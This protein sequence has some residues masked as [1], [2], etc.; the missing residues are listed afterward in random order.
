MQT[1]NDQKQAII[2]CALLTIG[3]TF[4]NVDVMVTS[5]GEQVISFVSTFITCVVSI[6]LLLRFTNVDV[7][8][9]HYRILIGVSFIGMT[10][11]ENVY[12]VILYSDQI[13]I[14]EYYVIFC[15]ELVLS[16]YVTNVIINVSNIL[17]HLGRLSL[18][19]SLQAKIKGRRDSKAEATRVYKKLYPVLELL[20][21]QGY[22]FDSLEVKGIVKVLGDLPALGKK[23]ENFAKS[24]LR[25]EFTLR[26][27]PRDPSCFEGQTLWH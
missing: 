7:I 12:P 18:L 20:L 3:S 11:L 16:I 24:Y 22:S 21:D 14:T 4:F 23:R 1:N 13:F 19:D 15:I 26:K 8:S 17:S 6:C 10:I 9:S 27:L 25:D 2:L 5:V